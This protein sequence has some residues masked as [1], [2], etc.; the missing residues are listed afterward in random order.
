LFLDNNYIWRWYGGQY[1]SINVMRSSIFS[2]GLTSAVFSL[3]SG[4]HPPN[5]KKFKL[6]E[7]DQEFTVKANVIEIP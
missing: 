7:G 4:D 5:L 1:L 2:L 3:F 6:E